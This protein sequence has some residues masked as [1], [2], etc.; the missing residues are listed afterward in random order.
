MKRTILPLMFVLFSAVAFAGD[1]WKSYFKNNEVEILYRKADC[2]DDANGIHQQKILLKVVNLQ[3]KKVEVFYT[4]EL[5]FS[6]ADA[7]ASAPDV[8]EFSVTLEPNATVEGDC[9][10]RD[11]RLFIFSKHLNFSGTELKKFDLKNISVKPIQ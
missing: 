4:K 6:K 10:V 7:T 5:N 3:N 2:N 8:R 9:K 11:N 1:D